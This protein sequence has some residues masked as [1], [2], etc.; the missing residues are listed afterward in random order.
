VGTRLARKAAMPARIV[1]RVPGRVRIKVRGV[2]EDAEFFAVVQQ[3]IAGLTGVESVR[4]N[5][6]SSSIVV[7]YQLS[8]ELFHSSL[9][10]DAEVRSWIQLSGEEGLESAMEDVVTEGLRYLENHS[11]LAESIVVTAEYLDSSLRKASD[12]LLDLKVLLPLGVVAATTLTKARGRGTP[13]WITLGSFAFNAFLT[14]HRR[15]ID[16]PPVHIVPPSRHA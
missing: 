13:M 8:D 12:G 7:D 9:R 6:T 11:R 3:L 2:R 14:L 1:H 5:P 16:R 15:R 4:V 10:G